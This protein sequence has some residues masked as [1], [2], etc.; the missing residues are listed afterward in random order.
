M[1]NKWFIGILADM[2]I[3]IGV[4]FSVQSS[5]LQSGVL[6]GVRSQW[7]LITFL[8]LFLFFHAMY[9]LLFTDTSIQKRIAAVFPRPEKKAI[10]L[11][12]SVGVYLFAFFQLIVLLVVIALPSFDYGLE[13]SS[14]VGAVFAILLMLSVAVLVTLEVVLRH[15]DR[16]PEKQ[17]QIDNKWHAFIR[18]HPE[19]AGSLYAL[20]SILAPVLQFWLARAYIVSANEYDNEKQPLTAAYIAL[21]GVAFSI[22]LIS[23]FDVVISTHAESLQTIMLQAGMLFVFLYLPLKALL[24]LVTQ[25]KH[26]WFRELCIASVVFL[27]QLGVVY[28]YL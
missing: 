12:A 28:F 20:G 10:N 1:K 7:V 5:G 27:L 4:F 15:V 22:I 6:E 24:V 2:L 19:G 17:Q 13:Q 14:W 26:V 11:L 9:W 8:A 16:T 3:F 23:A 18:K 25:Q 21:A